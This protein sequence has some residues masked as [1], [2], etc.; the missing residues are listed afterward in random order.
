MT[1]CLDKSQQGDVIARVI[2]NMLERGNPTLASPHVDRVLASCLDIF[3]SHN[4]LDYTLTLDDNEQSIELI[5]D[6]LLPVMPDEAQDYRELYPFDSHEE[7]LFLGEKLNAYFGIDCASL[8]RQLVIPQ[9][10]LEKMVTKKGDFHSQ[11]VDF[12]WDLPGPNGKFVV[13]IDGQQHQ[14]QNAL[15][16]DRKRDTALKD[17]DWQV[18]RIST[19]ELYGNAEA[20]LAQLQPLVSNTTFQRILSRS[21]YTYNEAFQKLSSAVLV[22]IAVG[23]IQRVLAELVEQG[24][25]K[26]SEPQR[27]NLA[28]YEQ[29]VP[30]A[31]LAI[32]DF[33]E[34]LR[35]FACMTSL[36][37]VPDITLT[38]IRDS[39]HPSPL[40]LD[41]TVNDLG[42]EYHKA[43]INDSFSYQ[44]FDV[45]LDFAIE[46]PPNWISR[47]E[48]LL[49]C[50]KSVITLRSVYRAV[51]DTRSLYCAAPVD[52]QPEEDALTY[53]LRY[54]FRKL[55]FRDGQR[56]IIDRALASKDVIGLLPTGGGKSICYQLPALLQ[57]GMTLVVDPIKSLMLDQREELRAIGMD[58]S[59]FINSSLTTI[60]REDVL[61]QMIQGKHQF[62]FVSPE[63]LQIE[64]FRDKLKRLRT[65]NIHFTYAVVDEA[66]C[67]S[68]WGHDFRTAYLR[69]GE[70]L[71]KYLPT[72]LSTA[73]PV[74][75][76]TGTASYDV[77][78]DIQR[79]LG[80]QD[81]AA[82]I[83]PATLKRKELSF[84]IIPVP[85]D[86]L[87][88]NERYK[89]ARISAQKRIKIRELLQ[90]LPLKFSGTP[91]E[92]NT[93]S[94][95]DGEN[96]RCG[97]IF[98]PHRR[99]DFGI[100]SGKSRNGLF[101]ELTHTWPSLRE[102]TG[103]YYGS[104]DDSDDK[105]EQFNNQM[106][107]MQNRFK[108]NELSLL[109]ATKAFGMGVNKPNVRYTIHFNIPS[110]IEAFYQEAGRAGRDQSP[111]RC[112]VLLS[113]AENWSDTEVSQWFYDQSFKGR[114]REAGLV[115]GIL[116]EN[117]QG[118][119][120]LKSWA[121]L[122]YGETRKIN[123]PKE[124]FSRLNKY[125]QGLI[126]SIS[127][128]VDLRKAFDEAKDA[129]AFVETIAKTVKQDTVIKVLKEDLE[130]P[131]LFN[132][133]RVKKDA[134]KVIYRLA[135]IGLV[136]DYTVDYKGKQYCIEI[137]KQPDDFYIDTLLNYIGLYVSQNE[138]SNKRKELLA[139][140]GTPVIQRCIKYLIEFIYDRIANKRSEAIKIMHSAAQE[141][142][143]NSQA[144]DDRV[145][146]YFNSDYIQELV[147]SRIE[148][149]DETVWRFVREVNSSADTKDRAKHLR[150]SCDRLL[151]DNPDNGAYHLLRAF[152][153]LI[154]NPTSPEIISDARAGINLFQEKFSLS[155]LEL[156]D[157]VH[158][159]C[160]YLIGAD[161]QEGERISEELIVEL[162]GNWLEGFTQTY[163][164][165][166]LIN[167]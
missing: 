63:R 43:S 129:E 19:K 106:T 87:P 78:T 15:T 158:K 148:Y 121:E 119:T 60:Q 20:K 61:R 123:I 96:T 22:P 50:A 132:S 72:S 77:L 138:V 109:L 103:Y 128:S 79:D 4:D 80:I 134:E 133:I 62:I 156:P 117:F 26:W 64:D 55:N 37:T 51:E 126:G 89:K 86:S 11:R 34:L 140:D 122:N 114:E 9:H 93:F 147:A 41:T 145:S 142:I 16:A 127:K 14:E 143:N 167:G 45:L 42:F 6:A 164:K 59:E 139:D 110:S 113:Q 56:R 160:N 76:L 90:S 31:W 1:P 85:I 58:R 74:L 54:F 13:E 18:I 40:E 154:I 70:N 32:N 124:S 97:I 150:G 136:A 146:N 46:Q 28:V 105:D 151:V 23:R 92:E 82:V 24:K 131:A 66:H 101:D 73:V 135:T 38:V 39:L 112:F 130:F 157:F 33:L 7:A 17:A 83:R 12:A 48:K 8:L 88:K 141:G 5:M 81:E 144:F 30:C 69:L 94:K 75:G 161:P 36:I 120:I 10:S 115:L 2:I 49:Q 68:E 104:S 84:E 107:E 155:E 163:F 125:I 137:Q 99:G 25:L 47:P 67:V 29:D 149:D 3:H 44:Q 52:Y 100:V 95:L 98:L 53:F 91:F 118:T 166:V 165:G 152:A 153:T 108:R 35:S 111:A 162:H 21:Q 159:F 27:W 65:R 71:R 102:T 116:N 57:P